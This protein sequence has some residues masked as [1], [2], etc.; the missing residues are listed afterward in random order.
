MASDI[1]GIPRRR[2]RRDAR[3]R[4]A[5]ARRIALVVALGVLI[6]LAVG[7]IVLPRIATDR[8]TAS[9]ARN[10]Q[11]VHVSI[12]AFPAVE[13]LFGNADSVKVRISRLVAG[14]RHVGDLLTRAGGV[15]SLDARVGE[16][17]TH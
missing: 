17:E 14:S 13:L 4:G 9:L 8:L 2:P 11:G 15:S 12:S 6:V 5:V 7:Q 1:N 10:G 3:I 16:L